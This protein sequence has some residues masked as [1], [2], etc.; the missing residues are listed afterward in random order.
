MGKNKKSH[1]K[2]PSNWDEREVLRD[3]GQ[4]WTPSWVAEA[5]VSYVFR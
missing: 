4:F 2:L 5:M 3:K 1:Q